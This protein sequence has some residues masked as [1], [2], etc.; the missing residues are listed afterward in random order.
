MVRT[1]YLGSLMDDEWIRDEAIDAFIARCP[2]IAVELISGLIAKAI[3]TDVVALFDTQTEVE[4][5]GGTQGIEQNQAAHDRVANAWST[6]RARFDS[7]GPLFLE[8]YCLWPLDGSGP[9]PAILYIGSGRSIAAVLRGTM[10]GSLGRLALRAVRYCR[11]HEPPPPPPALAPY[12]NGP[13]QAPADVQSDEALERRR[14]EML[15]ERCEWNIALV[16]RKL[17]KSRPTVYRILDR[18]S[19]PRKRVSKTPQ[20]PPD[21]LPGEPC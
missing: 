17:R 5:L 4:L 20:R 9:P 19:I 2:R 18:L 16:G 11:V 12:I 21:P 6:E 10:D 8:S 15:M 7:G 13:A 14:V 1:E 3:V